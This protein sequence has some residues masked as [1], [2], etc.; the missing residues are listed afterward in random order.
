M[1]NHVTDKLRKFFRQPDFYRPKLWITNIFGARFAKLY[2]RFS[3]FSE[4]PRGFVEL[5]QLR[6]KGD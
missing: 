2:K 3:V 5:V 1:G 6:M 4:M